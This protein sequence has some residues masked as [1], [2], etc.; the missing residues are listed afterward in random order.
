MIYIKVIVTTGVKKESIIEKKSN[1]FEI[2]VKEK[3]ERNMAN[4]RVVEII[5]NYFKVSVKKVRIINGHHHPHKLLVVDS[6]I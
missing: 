5:A 4:K 2:S 6:K 1:Y 3:A